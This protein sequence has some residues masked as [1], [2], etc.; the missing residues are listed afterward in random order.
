MSYRYEQTINALVAFPSE[1]DVVDDR[2]G[3]SS[4]KLIYG[5]RSVTEWIS[6][7]TQYRKQF[8]NAYKLMIYHHDRSDYFMTKYCNL[9]SKGLCSGS[10][11]QYLRSKFFTKLYY[12]TCNKFCD[13]ESRIVGT[14]YYFGARDDT[15]DRKSIHRIRRLFCFVRLYRRR[16]MILYDIVYEQYDQWKRCIA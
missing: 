1:R 14:R 15:S 3:G 12:C 9:L 16:S 4:P 13:R 11:G 7:A 5:F 10:C 2:D 8:C 6:M